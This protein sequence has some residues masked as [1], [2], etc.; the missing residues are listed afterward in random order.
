MIKR[1]ERKVMKYDHIYSY[2]LQK[3]VKLGA[4]C[5]SFVKE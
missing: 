5:R 2:Y 3:L 4:E 1:D